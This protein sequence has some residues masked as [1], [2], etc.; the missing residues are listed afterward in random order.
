MREGRARRR[1]RRGGRP[2]QLTRVT[3]REDPR[4]RGPVAELRG[5]PANTP[6]DAGPH[7]CCSLDRRL[8]S[9]TGSRLS[10]APLPARPDLRTRTGRQGLAV[11]WG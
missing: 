6:P 7:L 10:P 9:Q 3:A 1:W 8:V 4:L 5:T 11:P 2:G